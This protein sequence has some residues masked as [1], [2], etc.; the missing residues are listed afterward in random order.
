MRG[1]PGN[2]QV[3]VLKHPRFVDMEK[4]IA[5]GEC[6][7]K[8]PR[9]V[10][11]AYNEGISKRKAAYI[12]YP[13]AV[14]QKYAIDKDNCIFFEK[15][16]CRACEKFCPTGAVKFD[17]R[18]ETVTLQVGSVVLAPGFAPFD[19]KGIRTWGYG[20]YSNVIT[21]M[22][23]ERVLSASGPTEGHLL[24][25]S[26]KKEAAKIAFLQCVG[27]RDLN[28]ASNGYCSSVCCT[29]AI[30]EAMIAK[31]HVKDLDVTIFFM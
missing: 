6:A 11:D 18:E 25:P 9:K 14:P 7:A 30:K 28:K 23:M 20:F 21:S 17:D 1:E 8:C 22:E 19:P 27:S 31:D 29:Y 4:C 16:K 12:P 24:R 3:D 10:D 13:Q 5:C 26:D 2:F 15:G